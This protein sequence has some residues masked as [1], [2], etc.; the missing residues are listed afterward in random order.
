MTDFIVKKLPY[1]LSFHA[2]LAL[3]GKHL[4]RI[5][6]NAVVD[7]AFPVRSGVANSDVIKGY[8]GLLCLGVTSRKVVWLFPKQ[9]RLEFVP[10]FHGLQGR[11][12]AQG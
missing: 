5:K 2:G 12:A 8:L 11:L 1:A 9:L 4:K 10:V 3:I 6:T 7:P